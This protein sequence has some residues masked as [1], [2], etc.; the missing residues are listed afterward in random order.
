[1]MALPVH[2]APSSA[3]GPCERKSGALTL[4]HNLGP[5]VLDIVVKKRSTKPDVPVRVLAA[6]LAGGLG[7]GLIAALLIQW[8]ASHPRA[9]API[10]ITVYNSENCSCC[11][12][13][14]GHLRENGFDVHVEQYRQDLGRVNALM[15]IPKPLAACHTAVVGP[16]M[17]VGHVP[18]DDI[19]RLLAERPKAR[20]LAVPGMPVGSP[21]M[22]QGNRREPYEVL[23]FQAS[24]DAVV[25]ARHGAQT[26]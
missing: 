9:K 13:W 6:W 2:M 10:R 17:L 11:L 4:G 22:E 16:Y 20:G 19:R 21:G 7:A 8:D 23:L 12:K 25:F 14:A 15:G 1:M 24:G 5:R 18:A 26:P 3:G